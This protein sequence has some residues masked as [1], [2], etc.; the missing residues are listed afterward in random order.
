MV[1]FLRILIGLLNDVMTSAE[2]SES[3][4][5]MVSK[6]FASKLSNT[7]GDEMQY[8]QCDERGVSYIISERKVGEGICVSGFWFCWE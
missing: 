1:L 6:Y 3:T 2:C 8:L 5:C 7:V 4:E